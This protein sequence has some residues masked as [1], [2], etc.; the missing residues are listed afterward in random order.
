MNAVVLTGHG[1]L[2][3]LE[4][5]KDWPVPKI[6]SD[7]VLIKVSA[8]GLNNTDVNTRTAWY[9]KNVTDATTGSAFDS[10][11]DDDATWGGAPLTFP[12]IQGA[13]IC[14]TVVASATLAGEHLVGRRVMVEPWVRDWRDPDNASLCKY[15]GSECDGGYAEYLSIHYRQVHVVE[16]DLSNA[17]IATF[18]TS[19]LT[20]ENMLDQA[21]VTAGDTVLITG[22][23]GG[24]GSALIQLA[25]RRDAVTVAMASESK[26]EALQAFEPD[27]IVSRNPQ[28]I[29]ADLKREIGNSSVSVVLDVVG[30][31][32]WPQLIGVLKRNGR[33][34]CSG[35][36]AGP[37]VP[38]D[39]RTL[40][41][42]DLTFF[43]CTIVPRGTFA[44]LVD[45]I[46]KDEVSPVIA[47]I[48]PLS[49]LKS[50]QKALISKQHVGNIVVSVERD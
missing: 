43:G 1:D 3:K 26:H 47:A 19:W 4:F 23:S 14:G 2:D 38:L 21:Q 40:Y 18:A 50:A 33:Y 34:A 44:K 7:H 13:D 8:C 11:A 45:Y 22:A 10:A 30:G 9:S 37:I 46:E 25:K 27:A 35:A 20:A 12:R 32:I 17:E 36:I 49:E 16:C 6:E 48:Y 5:H 15:L 42:S 28:D 39:L 29:S 31:S 41:L 24:V